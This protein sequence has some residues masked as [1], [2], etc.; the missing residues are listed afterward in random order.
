VDSTSRLRP[1]W[2]KPAKKHPPYVGGAVH[3]GLD[4][5][6]PD[7]RAVPPDSLNNPPQLACWTMSASQTAY[8]GT[9]QRYETTYRGFGFCPHSP[10]PLLLLLFP[11]PIHTHEVDDCL[12]DE[13]CIG[14]KR[15]GKTRERARAD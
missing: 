4:M 13:L 5:D 7:S 12:E 15:T 8:V 6:A 14:E 10:Q 11:F 1:K 3:H 2:R 9:G